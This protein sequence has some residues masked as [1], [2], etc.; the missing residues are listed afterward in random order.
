MSH[1]ETATVSIAAVIMPLLDTQHPTP[2]GHHKTR[3]NTRYH[4]PFVEDF[5]HQMGDQKLVDL[6]T[7]QPEIPWTLTEKTA[8][9]THMSF[10]KGAARSQSGQTLLFLQPHRQ[11]QETK[12]ISKS[13]SVKTVPKGLQ[14]RYNFSREEVHGHTS[15]GFLVDT[16]SRIALLPTFFKTFQILVAVS[17]KSSLFGKIM[18]WHGKW[19]PAW[20][21]QKQL[22]T[23]RQTTGP[24][25]VH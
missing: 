2:K 7:E 23:E 17:Q 16:L 12:K 18:N 6:C 9:P 25:T 4:M 15:L 19:C 22:E 5:A 14:K 21:A 10:K 3:I 8:P 24:S 11:P 20:K 13:A 1:D